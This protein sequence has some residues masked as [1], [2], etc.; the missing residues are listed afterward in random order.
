M[1]ALFWQLAADFCLNAGYHQLRFCGH[2]NWKMQQIIVYISDETANCPDPHKQ[3]M[4]R[5]GVAE[6]LCALV[7][8]VFMHC[9]PARPSQARWT[10]IAHVAQWTLGLALFHQFLKPLFTA[11]SA[12]SD[13]DSKDSDTAGNTMDADVRVQASCS[14][15]TVD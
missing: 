12:K 5:R 3:T 7:G 1:I 8:Y 11:L 10:G 2:S 15:L 4:L 14:L 9:K 6:H 13:D